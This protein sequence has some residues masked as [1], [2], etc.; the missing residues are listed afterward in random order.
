MI[1]KLCKNCDNHI[2]KDM[3]SSMQKKYIELCLNSNR[4]RFISK[5]ELDKEN[6]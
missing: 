6:K 1:E 5:E 3:Y 4:S 2:C